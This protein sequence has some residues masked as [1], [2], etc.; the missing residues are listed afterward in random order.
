MQPLTPPSMKTMSYLI[1]RNTFVDA[2]F[3][4]FYIQRQIWTATATAQKAN[5]KDEWKIII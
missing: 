4:L 5:K 2:A 3:H 1:N